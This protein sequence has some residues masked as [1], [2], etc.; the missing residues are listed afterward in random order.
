MPRG[1]PKGTTKT[2]PYRKAI[3]VTLEPSTIERLD[4][5]AKALKKP[6]SQVV[7]SAILGYVEACEEQREIAKKIV[8]AWE[9][10]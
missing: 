6:R 2:D 5:T 4:V 3:K 8:A 7:E 9:E 1:R 10:A